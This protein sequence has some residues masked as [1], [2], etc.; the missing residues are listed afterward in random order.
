M[1][2]LLAAMLVLAV[3]S[4]A[5][6]F[7]WL[8][9]DTEYA[10]DGS[11]PYA[12]WQG[13][14]CGAAILAATVAGYLALRRLSAVLLLPAAAVVGFAVPWAA[15]ASSSDQTGLWAAGLLFLLIGGWVG[16]AMPVGLLATVVPPREGR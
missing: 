14:G 11:G 1:P 6:W 5:M 15:E 16:L 12:A 8:G 10:A 3:F 4:A 9:W 2:R 13:I 7:A